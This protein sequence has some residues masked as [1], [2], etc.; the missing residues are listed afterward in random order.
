MTTVEPKGQKLRQAVKWIS[1][2]R[3]EDEKNDFCLLIQDASSIFNL[4]P[5]EEEFLMVF[6]NIKLK[7]Q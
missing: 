1:E 5:N 4:N 7:E 6:Y 3:V 2:K